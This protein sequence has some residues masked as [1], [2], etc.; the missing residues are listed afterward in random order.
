[1]TFL[2]VFIHMEEAAD[3]K[4]MYN[5]TFNRVYEHTLNALMLLKGKTSLC[6][7]AGKGVRQG[8]ENFGEVREK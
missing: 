5:L 8:R 3:D 4:D 7:Y 1:M 2:E 6:P